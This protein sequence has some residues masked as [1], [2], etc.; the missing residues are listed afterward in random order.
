MFIILRTFLGNKAAA[1]NKVKCCALMDLHPNRTRKV[2]SNIKE[3]TKITIH[4][5]VIFYL[6]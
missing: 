5:M 1:I 4:R 6:F 2:R 3:H